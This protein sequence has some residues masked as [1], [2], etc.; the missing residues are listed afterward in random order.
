MRILSI[1]SSLGTQLAVVDAAPS[2]A[3]ASYQ[4]TFPARAPRRC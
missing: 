4:Q 2:A 1:D 3:M